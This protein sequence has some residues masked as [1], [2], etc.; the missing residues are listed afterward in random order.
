MVEILT[1]GRGD[2]GN[3]ASLSWSFSLYP[4]LF[5]LFPRSISLL[6]AY[7][8]S[9]RHVQG[10]PL[11][12]RLPLSLSLPLLSRLVR[13]SPSSTLLRLFLSRSR[14]YS[15]IRPSRPLLVPTPSQSPYLYASPGSTPIYVCMYVSMYVPSSIST[16]GHLDA[17]VREE[18]RKPG[19]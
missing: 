2:S 4:F 9:F 11:F 8:L 16:A 10:N 17:T 12:P 6:A 1:D 7:Y 18:R 15:V 13:P 3:S 14:F 19:G 5:F